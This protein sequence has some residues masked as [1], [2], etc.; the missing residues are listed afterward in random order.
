MTFIA[1]K[2]FQEEG[3]Y[4]EAL[5]FPTRFINAVVSYIEYMK[6]VIWPENLAFFY[7][8]P[9]ILYGKDYCVA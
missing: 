5:T 1:Q 8:L 9:E 3:N 4:I 2:R 7:P 6:K